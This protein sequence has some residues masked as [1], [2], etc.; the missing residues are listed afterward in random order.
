LSGLALLPA[1]AAAQVPRGTHF[2]VNT[3]TTGYQS[4]A[5]VAPGAGD[6]FV[7]VWTSAGQDGSDRGVFMRRYSALGIAEGEEVQV[8]AY[9]AGAQEWPTV[10]SDSTGNFVIAW[11]SFGQEAYRDVFAQ[12]FDA[13]GAPLGGEFRVNELTAGYQRYPAV[14]AD[15]DGNFV[16][17]WSGTGI[18]DDFGIF[19]R[20]YD[21]DGTALGGEFLVNTYT[22]G[23]HI[24]PEVAA[25]AGGGFM[26]V[27]VQAGQDGSNLGVFAQRFDETGTKQGPE[28]FVNAYTTGQ[29]NRPA[30]TARPNGDFVI[31]W[32]SQTASAGYDVRARHYLASASGLGPEFALG[33]ETF[34]NQRSPAMGTDARG[35]FVTA[36][37]S[38][39]TGTYGAF[40]RRFHRRY[41]AEQPDFAVS[42]GNT[43][44]QFFPAVA[45]AAA[46]NFVVAWDEPDGDA[47]GVFARR[48]F[49]DV[50]LEDRFESGDTSGWSAANTGG[51]DLTVTPA[52]ELGAGGFGLQAMVD[53]T[54]GLFVQD[55]GPDDEGRYRARF[56]FD[57]N[58]FDPGEALNRRRVRLFVAFDQTPQQRRIVAVVLRRLGGAYALRARARLDDNSQADTPFVSITPGAHSMEL[59]WQRASGPDAADGILEMWIDGAPAA[60]LTGLD[61]SAGGVDAGRLG[62][63][64]V[65]PGANGVLYFDEFESRRQG[66]IVP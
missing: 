24:S 2:Q 47:Q 61:A 29:Q 27:W 40:G 28:L 33:T 53:D 17:V 59:D 48:F 26:A 16:V 62:A 44:N 51:G 31:A 3:Y 43:G 45:V 20:R 15:A 4:Q 7:V 25:Q 46:G 21:A 50:I 18:G 14:A 10:A 52:A 36:W 32:S 23:A 1:A 64:S 39:H 8:N 11:E 60:T 5:V 66:D 57:T 65:K 38:L 19:A 9:T 54:A 58:G 13:S 35:N 63:I 49:P 30:V 34:S 55:D 22:T 42:P 12:R 56:Y 6:A 37:H 41:G